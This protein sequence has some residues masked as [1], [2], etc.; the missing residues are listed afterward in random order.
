MK[1]IHE[2][3]VI[4]NDQENADVDDKV[5]AQLWDDGDV[6]I[7]DLE[8]ESGV[9]ISLDDLEQL[10]KSLQ[11]NLKLHKENERYKKENK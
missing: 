9:F 6:S 5:I 1:I 3:T 11:F 8:N 4:Y 10:V 2:E 7:K